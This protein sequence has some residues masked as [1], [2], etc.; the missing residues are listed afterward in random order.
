MHTLSSEIHSHLLCMYLGYTM[1]QEWVR[2]T[3]RCLVT[4]PSYINNEWQLEVHFIYTLDD[5]RD[6]RLMHT[7]Q[8]NRSPLHPSW[9]HHNCHWIQ[10][11]KGV[12][13]VG[14]GEVSQMRY[15]Q[16]PQENNDASQPGQVS[17]HAVRSMRAW[18]G[19]G[20]GKDPTQ[21][22]GALVECGWDLAF[23]CM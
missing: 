12:Q 10:S 16:Y 6:H 17:Q 22:G 21:Q 9:F 2:L 5:N 15:P 23:D 18:L 13:S 19:S 3:S 7:C 8:Y 14:R 4:E 1:H 20:L 11:Q